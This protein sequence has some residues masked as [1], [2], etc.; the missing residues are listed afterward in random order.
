M[1][2]AELRKFQDLRKLPPIVDHDS[3]EW[4]T[5]D[6]VVEGAYAIE[7]SHEG[8]EITALKGMAE[9]WDKS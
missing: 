1:S 9:E 6:D 7:I 8:G 5:F 3:D 4:V 2:A